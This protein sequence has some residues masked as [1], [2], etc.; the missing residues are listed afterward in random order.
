MIKYKQIQVKIHM[1]LQDTVSPRGY[2]ICS[3]PGGIFM[4]ELKS[5]LHLPDASPGLT[6]WKE[7]LFGGT[8]AAEH[9]T[10]ADR[11]AVIRD[12]AEPCASGNPDG[13][14][15]SELEIFTVTFDSPDRLF[16]VRD[17]II[18]RAVHPCLM[19]LQ[20]GEQGFLA[21]CRTA[22]GE[23]R[24]GTAAQQRTPVSHFLYPDQ[25]TAPAAEFLGKVSA[26]L[27][28]VDSVSEIS[29]N[30][31][32]LIESFALGGV[33]GRNTL[34]F[35]LRYLVPDI[36][37][38]DLAAMTDGL[39]VWKRAT[40]RRGYVYTWDMEQVWHRLL[41]EP[42][43]RAALQERRIR[44]MEDLLYCCDIWRPGL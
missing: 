38:E 1:Y 41:Q 36:A 6:D 35:V 43:F 37:K 21:A 40:A 3:L 8:A 5:L 19:I 22:P 44:D 15:F 11:P 13:D 33:N 26:A 4:T 18:R 12:P 30:L 10:A 27:C 25:L 7:A 14:A 39:W 20:C 2:S 29:M 17:R 24:T 42:R 34:H 23:N 28:A 16:P 32:Q 9:V 31:I